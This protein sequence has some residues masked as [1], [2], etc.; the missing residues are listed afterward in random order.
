MN[1]EDFERV[2]LDWVNNFV[3]VD[4]YAEH[5]GLHRDEALDLIKLAWTVCDRE[6]P[7]K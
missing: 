1:R 3:S 7:E 5:Y 2:Y 4:G 6:H